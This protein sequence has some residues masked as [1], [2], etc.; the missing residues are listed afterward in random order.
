VRK[1][2]LFDIDGTL[3][4]AYG[5]GG[6]AM[7]R[8]AEQVLGDGC[9]GAHIEFGG[10]LDPWIFAQLAAHG[11][12]EVTPAVHA[13][14][15]A[16]YA[17]V[18]AEELSHPEARCQ[19]MPGVLDV[20]ARLRAERERPATIGLLTGNYAETAALKLRAAGIDPG[21]FEIAAWGDLA[22]ER[23]ALVPVAL[24]QL[25]HALSAKDVVIVGDTVRDVHCARVNGCP[26]V[27]VATGGASA[28]ELHAAGADVVLDDLRDA[29]PLLRLLG[30][31]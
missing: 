1:L 22:S 18:L 5:A 11:G 24:G 14:F 15:R 13:T 10:A 2:V 12:Y 7:R 31:A 16:R 23:H 28:R 25:S 17:Q 3:L 19:A 8:A 4:R 30:L 26:C 29:S 21:W 9:R 27:A 6:R 20:L